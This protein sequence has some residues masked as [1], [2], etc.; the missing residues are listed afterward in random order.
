MDKFTRNYVDALPA[1]EE[2]PY[3]RHVRFAAPLTVCIDGKTGK[4]L[5]TRPKE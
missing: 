1:V 5:I 2:T 3:L 4:A